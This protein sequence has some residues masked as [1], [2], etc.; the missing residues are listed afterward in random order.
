MLGEC[1]AKAIMKQLGREHV[2]R[3]GE[4]YV[5]VL[6][7]SRSVRV[8]ERLDER[9]KVGEG[10]RLRASPAVAEFAR[11]GALSSVEAARK[12][13]S[14]VSS[15]NNFSLLTKIEVVVVHVNQ[16]RTKGCMIADLSNLK[17]SSAAN[18]L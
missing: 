3:H 4:I 6:V 14:E 18:G 5:A 9:I 13:T 8:A 7:L 2:L 12:N 11:H 10:P 17:F 15:R 1:A 16:P